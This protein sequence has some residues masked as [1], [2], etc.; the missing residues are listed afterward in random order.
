MITIRMKKSRSKIRIEL[1]NICDEL[2]FFQKQ[3]MISVKN[4]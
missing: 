3:I 2:W 4:A 1:L